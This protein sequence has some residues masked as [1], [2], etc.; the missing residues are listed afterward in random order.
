M[1]KRLYDSHWIPWV[2]IV[3]KG[4]FL[5]REL[6]PE[7]SGAACIVHWLKQRSKLQRLVALCLS[8]AE[9]HPIR[10]KNVGGE[11]WV[12]SGLCHLYLDMF[13]C[14]GCPLDVAGYGC[15]ESESLFSKW[16][17]ASGNRKRKLAHKMF[18]VMMNIYREEYNRY[19]DARD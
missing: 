18:V 13:D 4:R 11:Y 3:E 8:V 6:V 19:F 10:G 5:N 17:D 9:W 15:L 12:D 1:P 14:N 2:R 7:E 16:V